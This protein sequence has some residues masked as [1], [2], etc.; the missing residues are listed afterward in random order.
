[1]WITEDCGHIC[2]CQ[3][4]GTPDCKSISD[5]ETV[6]HE[7]AMCNQDQ[8]GAWQCTCNE[9]YTGDGMVCVPLVCPGG[10]SKKTIF[11]PMMTK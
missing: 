4:T 1:M 11:V 7:N 8:D 3:T 9:D 2:T 10:F 5:S 6:C